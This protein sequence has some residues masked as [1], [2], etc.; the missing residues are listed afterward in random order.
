MKRKDS[1]WKRVGKWYDTLVTEKGH[2]YHQT[3]ILPTLLSWLSLKQGDSILDLA[4]GQGVLARH[5]P[6]G[7]TYYGLDAAQP[8]I[9]HAKSYSKNPRHHFLL[10]D[11]E[12][13][14]HIDH[15]QFDSA[16]LILAFQN[17]KH[18]QKALQNASTYLKKGGKMVLALNHPC[19]RI[20]RQSSWGIDEKKG[21]QYRRIDR[22][23]SSLDI[24]IDMHPSEKNKKTTTLSFHWPLSKI[25]QYIFQSGLVITR[26]EE[27]CSNK[28]SV[29]RKAKMENRAR[30]E[31]PL[32]L[33]IE[34]E[35]Y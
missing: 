32:F 7:V 23:M 24:P 17:I 31:F 27:W 19:Y 10:Q 15:K 21:V 22:Y 1:S 3:I 12:K 13:P 14:F 26:L 4:C 16:A 34:C 35:K 25:S 5:L 20:P 2:Y 8:L 9:K 11:I 30:E 18:P 6:E 33:G 29:G 28:K